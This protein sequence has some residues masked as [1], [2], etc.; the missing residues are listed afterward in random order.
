MTLP[1]PCVLS[2]DLPRW[3]GALV[4]VRSQ[5]PQ[6]ASTRRRRP[7]DASQEDSSHFD[8]GLSG[9]PVGDSTDDR[10]G[11]A[12][13]LFRVYIPKTQLYAE[14]RREMLRLF[15]VWLTTV[16]GQD[17]R[18]QDFS[19]K[20][21]DTIAFYVGQG[22]LRPALGEEYREFVSFVEYSVHSPATAIGQLA[23]IGIDE[24]T[25]RELVTDYAMKYHRMEMDLRHARQSRL[26]SLQQ[27]LEGQLLDKGANPQGIAAI[28]IDREIRTVI[29]TT[30]AIVISSLN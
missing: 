21:G 29:Y 28:Q 19:T 30:N 27:T 24:S 23:E 6:A 7:H 9:E 16:Q 25:G 8:F 15:R 17:V 5:R 22:Q 1:C 13:L 26:L 14:Q 4:R 12:D 2:V 10:A 20:H 3:E 11:D 18:Q